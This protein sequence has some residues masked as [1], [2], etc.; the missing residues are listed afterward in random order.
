MTTTQHQRDQ[1]IAA[2]DAGDDVR[3]VTIAL[4]IAA[5]MARSGNTSGAMSIRS[6]VDRIHAE[7]HR[8][9]EHRKLRLEIASRLFAFDTNASVQGSISAAD[10]L[11]EANN[12]APIPEGK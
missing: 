5:T 6:E 8:R 12:L 11:I 3:A 4:S 9:V 1:M 2:F 10:Q 7:A